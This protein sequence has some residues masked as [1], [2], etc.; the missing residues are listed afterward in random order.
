[1]RPLDRLPLRPFRVGLAA[2]LQQVFRRLSI[3]VKLIPT[4]DELPFTGFADMGEHS[5]ELVLPDARG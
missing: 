2:A 3:E 5:F 1:M 4:L